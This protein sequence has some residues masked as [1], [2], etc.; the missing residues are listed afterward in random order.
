MLALFALSA[1]NAAETLPVPAESP[2]QPPAFSNAPPEI[3][4]FLLRA[5][6]ADKIS[7]PLARCLAFPDLPGNK[8]P[9]G[10][11]K[12]HC[13]FMYGPRITLAKATELVARGATDELDALFAADLARHFSEDDFSEAI[14]R[15]FDDF[16]K[17]Y[18][19]GKFTKEW[20]EKAPNSAFALTARAVYYRSMA[21]EARGRNWASETPRE[22]MVRMREF[23][24]LAIPLYQR[25]L[26]IESRLLP[27]HVG[28]I[29]IGMTHTAFAD[30]KD[31]AIH[32]AKEVDPACKSITGFQMV[33]LEP[34]WGGSYPE[35]QGLSEEIAPFVAKRP[36]LALNTIWP[37][38]DRANMLYRDDE[39]DQ[40][41]AILTPIMEQ[42]SHPSPY[43]YLGLSMLQAE[44]GSLWQALVY[45]LEASR[46]DEGR[47]YVNRR[48]GRLLLEIAQR[49]EWAQKYAKLAVEQDPDD[50][51]AHYWLGMSY[52]SAGNWPLAE[53]EYRI[54][55]QDPG[56]R[57]D[58]LSDLVTVL[59]KSGQLKQARE[60][61][62]L[63]TT[64]FPAYALG[65]LVR[66]QVLATTRSEG[67]LEALQ[68]F[69][70]TVDR[71]DPRGRRIAEEVERW[72][73]DN[74]VQLPAKR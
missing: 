21:N 57:A 23:F 7:D 65:W 25:A 19:A 17:T 69:F 15:D 42:T 41:V 44:K 8:W 9:A 66:H 52:S 33:S 35:M 37:V 4:E 24:E 34:R 40:V 74:R 18:A 30:L 6:I 53:K 12:A 47:Q 16:S 73:K 29:D 63:L 10:L 68:K 60:Q 43:E 11:A 50:L 48:R 56:K 70:D 61:V 72:M 5:E 31:K 59:M 1:V 14:H 55:A 49:P 64:E 13:D 3:R 28:L 2:A 45:L 27:A 54:S 39:F 71:T 22:N 51:V 38:V 20:L 58:S 36:L 62:D 26:Q 32:A 46:F 67:S